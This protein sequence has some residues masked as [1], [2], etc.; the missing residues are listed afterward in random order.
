MKYNKHSG[1]I[2]VSFFME[3]LIKIIIWW[4]KYMWK[5]KMNKK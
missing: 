3:T 1:T 5:E 2:Q 4:I